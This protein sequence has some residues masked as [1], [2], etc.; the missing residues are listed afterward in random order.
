MIPE[1]IA[2]Y[3]NGKGG[4]RRMSNETTVG[5]V[6][7]AIVAS[8][9]IWYA[10]EYCRD[11]NRAYERLNEERLNCMGKVKPQAIKASVWRE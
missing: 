4:D 8:L 2:Q 10:I 11:V 7:I 3:G 9:L 5:I 1:R 6:Y